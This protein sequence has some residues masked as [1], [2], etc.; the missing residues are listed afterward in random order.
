MNRKNDG[1]YSVVDIIH[2]VWFIILVNKDLRPLLL[3]L[4]DL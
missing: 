3:H 4:S 2:G 1:L